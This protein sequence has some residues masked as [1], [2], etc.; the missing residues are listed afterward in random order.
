M[1]FKLIKVNN[2]KYKNIIIDNVQL[3][4]S[5]QL[6]DFNLDTDEYWIDDVE[7]NRLENIYQSNSSSAKS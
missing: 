1:K 5:S 2:F 4:I 3:L 6:N 7:I